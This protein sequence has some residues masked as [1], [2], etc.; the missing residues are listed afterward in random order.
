MGVRK[1]RDARTIKLQKKY[2]ISVQKF[3][4]TSLHSF[5]NK[6]THDII[7]REQFSGASMM[8]PTTQSPTHKGGRTSRTWFSYPRQTQE[9]KNN[10]PRLGLQA[11]GPLIGFS[12]KHDLTHTHTTRHRA[13]KSHT[14]TSKV[15][16]HSSTTM[17]RRSF[18]R[19][20]SVPGE[21]QT[22]SW[23]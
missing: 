19:S 7:E 18:R 8:A 3:K 15:S 23:V 13:R 12:K 21:K 14:G 2:F 17:Q 6:G 16:P 10:P 1:V 11:E 4:K 5:K 9:K 22:D 20:T